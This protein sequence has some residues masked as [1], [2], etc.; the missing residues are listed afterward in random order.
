T[1]SLSE[2]VFKEIENGMNIKDVKLDEK[3]HKEIRVQGKLEY[4]RLRINGL[5]EKIKKL[6]D[7]KEA[8]EARMTSLLNREIELERE[9]MN[10]QG[11]YYQEKDR[12]EERTYDLRS[13]IATLED[14][15]DNL[16]FQRQGLFSQN[17]RPTNEITNITSQIE[18]LTSEIRRKR[19]DR[20]DLYERRRWVRSRVMDAE[21]DLKNARLN[22][23]ELRL[24]L[25]KISDEIKF[26]R[27]ELQELQVKSE[28]PKW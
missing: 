22:I 7:Q 3:K 26:L 6:E 11:D 15:L 9:V 24:E 5:K 27:N 4:E 18:L 1:Q 2:D 12:I 23:R 8:D 16:R 19:N 21:R 25:T 13:E 28:M 20:N 17:P 10:E 14:K